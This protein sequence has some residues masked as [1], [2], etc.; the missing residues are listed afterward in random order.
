MRTCSSCKHWIQSQKRQQENLGSCNQENRLAVVGDHV[1]LP[2]M[3]GYQS[4]D[5]HAQKRGTE[6]EGGA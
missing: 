5:R 2:I 6:A 1:V 3:F 4:C